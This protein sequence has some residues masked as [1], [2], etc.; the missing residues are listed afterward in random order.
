MARKQSPLFELINSGGGKSRRGFQLPAWMRRDEGGEA[1]STDA[2]TQPLDPQYAAGSPSSA[3]TPAAAESAPQAAPA[4]NLQRW[5]RQP[6]LLRLPRGGLLLLALVLMV[7]VG[8][9]FWAG[10][11]LGRATAAQQLVEHNAAAEALGP[12][13]EQP[14]NPRLIPPSVEGV[15]SRGV[16]SD[17]PL[18]AAGAG[19]AGATIAG[20][21]RRP[22]LNYFRLMYVPA[23]NREE[24]ERA[25]AFLA[26]EGVDTAIVDDNNGRSLKL[27]ALPGFDSP[28]S[29]PQAQKLEDQLKLLG[30]KWK[31]QH[32]G[33][34][35]WKDL[36]PEKFRPGVN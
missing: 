22:G 13:L 2:Q 11:S 15:N 12:L 21:P 18:G 20:E 36:Y 9:A 27:V 32:R 25:A 30:R 29:D 7:L 1:A 19:G 3:S 28:R 33:S 6:A 17:A 31:A 14:I 4:S 26:S 5:L 35:D 24:I 34:S 8:A 23:K 16:G 10:R